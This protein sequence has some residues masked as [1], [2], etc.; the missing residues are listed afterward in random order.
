MCLAIPGRVVSVEGLD[1]HVDFRGV[2][3]A[4]RIDL[5][6]DARIGEWV[7]AHAGFAI[8]RL[9]ADEAREA[10]ATIDEAFAAVGEADSLP[11]GAPAGDTPAPSGGASGGGT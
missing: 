9:Q 11:A 5:L 7:L 6:P 8:Q 4:V 10:L 1:A 3:I 2:T